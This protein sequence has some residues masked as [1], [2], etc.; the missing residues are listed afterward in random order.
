MQAGRSECGDRL[1]MLSSAVAGMPLQA[2][3]GKLPGQALQQA[4]PFLF[5]QHAGG[6][7]RRATAVAAHQRVLRAIP[8]PQGQHTIDEKPMDPRQ[9]QQS[10]SHRPFRGQADAVTIDLGGTGLAD[11]P[12]V[13]L[14][15]DQGKQGL[16]TTG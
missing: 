11:R 15:A 13:S 14:G 6:S 8:A 5:G 2:I 3:T 10:A 4:I 12:A 1:A 9:L 16:A 7:N